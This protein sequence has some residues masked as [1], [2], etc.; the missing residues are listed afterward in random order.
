MKQRI[1]NRLVCILVVMAI[2]TSG[3]TVMATDTATPYYDATTRISASLTISSSGLA[4]C[5]GT[6][7]LSDSSCYANLTLKLQRYENHAW[8][9]V[10]TWTENDATSISGSRYVTSGY[11]YRVVHSANVY[12]SSG[13]YIESPSVTSSSKYY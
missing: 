12:S 1:R 2:L 10:Y 11:Y 3:M 5:S 9:T 4:S 7:R 6:I 8:T 13:K